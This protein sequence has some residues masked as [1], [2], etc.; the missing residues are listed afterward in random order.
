MNSIKILHTG[1]FHLGSVFKN[2][3]DKRRSFRKNEL[4]HTAMSILEYG[5][6]YDVVMLSGDVFDY[7][8][9]PTSVADMFL[10]KIKRYPHTVYVMSC[11]NHDPYYSPVIEY[12]RRNAPD[13]LT[14]FGCESVECVHMPEFNT[15]IYGISFPRVNQTDT[16]CDTLEQ[17]P[18][19]SINILC[20]HGDI[21]GGIYNP[22]SLDYISKC[23]IDY[24][25]LGH[26]HEFSGVQSFK[27]MK[28]AYCGIPEG[29]GFDE[30]GD[31]GFICGTISKGHADLTFKTVCVRKY[32]EKEVDI[33][34]CRDYDSVYKC[35]NK[36]VTS[37]DNLYRFSLVG[38]NNV[39]AFL[40][41][42]LIEN[43]IDAFY[44]RCTDCTRPAYDIDADA[45]LSDLRGMC[46]AE[47]LRL[48]GDSSPEDKIRYTK[49]YRVLMDVLDGRECM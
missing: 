45:A 1:D 7:P 6:E 10:D 26:I 31:K 13:N 46:A 47:T 5:S 9:C 40:R 27:T 8:D 24:V 39:T 2:L 15:R 32:M 30:C 12:C 16:L 42:E 4:M 44:I 21:N 19:D 23:G 33:S 20:V 43:V 22:V 25:A 49:A 11:G 14:V 35:I 29:R 18:G 3:D 28:Y 37:S 34:G 41:T 48:I 36:A 38:E 17:C